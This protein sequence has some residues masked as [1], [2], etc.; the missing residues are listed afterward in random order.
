[1]G[2]RAGVAA[3][4]VVA[5]FGVWAVLANAVLAGAVVVGAV[6]VGAVVV[7][8]RVVF[9]GFVEADVLLEAVTVTRFGALGRFGISNLCPGEIGRLRVMPFAL[10]RASIETL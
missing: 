1:L 9:A 2:L 6:V 5:W 10:Q 3:R 7:G 4:V 8:A